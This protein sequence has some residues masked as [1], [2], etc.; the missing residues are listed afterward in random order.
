MANQAV[1]AGYSRQFPAGLPSSGPTTE[2][3]TNNGNP[4]QVEIL[5]DGAFTDIT[6]LVYA[7]SPISISY[8]QTDESSV[9]NTGS[10]SFLINNRD[11]RFSPRNP[12]SPLYGKIGRN[13]QCKVSVPNGFGTN[14]RFWGE[15][16]TWP[17]NWDTTGLDVWVE[18]QASGILRRLTQ[19]ATALRSTLY[20]GLSGD[21]L[22]A[23][24]PPIAYW[25][26]ED[27]PGATQVAS[28]TNGPAMQ[29]SG[30]PTFANYSGAACSSP[31][32]T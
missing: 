25:P 10:C 3:G 11:G 15:I 7:R 21:D 18:V 2:N 13:T 4:V 14:T 20:Q 26:G 30:S 29:V 12:N 16:T 8:G 19:A 17:Q 27:G 1:R 9:A 31:L 28:A 5:I 32:P 22:A 6:P 24:N 23:V